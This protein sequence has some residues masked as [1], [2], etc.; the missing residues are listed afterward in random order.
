MKTTNKE[1]KMNRDKLLKWIKRKF[2]LY[3]DPDTI[4]G[5]FLGQNLVFVIM[6]FIMSQKLKRS[7]KVRTIKEEIK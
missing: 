1:A 4:V 7:S 5:P 3:E 2:L 6:C